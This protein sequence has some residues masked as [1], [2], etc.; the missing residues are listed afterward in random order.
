MASKN[1][2][3]IITEAG[4]QELFIV[5]EFEAPRHLV[6]K[7]FTEREILVKWVGPREMTIRYDY[8]EPKK[9]GSYRFI[10]TLPSG[11]EIGFQDR[12]STRLNSSH[13]IISYAV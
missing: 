11:L 3:Q 12:K 5:R 10:Q 1:Q 4:K 6:F 2:T 7:A 8:F 13:Q 9:G